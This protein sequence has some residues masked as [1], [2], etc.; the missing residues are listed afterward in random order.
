[1][2]QWGREFGQ[3]FSEQS[4]AQF[5]SNR[6]QM[7]TRAQ[8]ILPLI[9]ESS[10]LGNVAAEKYEEASRLM[11]RD[12]DRKGLSLIASSFKKDAEIIQLLKSQAELASDTT[13]NDAKA[14]NDKFVSLT[15]LIKEKQ[16]EKDHQ[17]AEGKRLILTH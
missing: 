15:G 8:K 4:R 9:E 5:P 14:F 2:E 16:K 6:D 12:Q 10:R 17:F 3:I 1:M 13:I 7:T 11:T